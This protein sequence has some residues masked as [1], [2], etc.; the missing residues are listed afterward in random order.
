VKFVSAR[1]LQTNPVAVWKR[2]RKQK[3][4]VITSN[5]KPVGVLTYADED[6]LKDVLT[7]LRQGRALSAAAR[8]RERATEKHLDQVSDHDTET[9]IQRTRARRSKAML[10]RNR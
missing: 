6:S 5:E 3:D 1:D 7:I 2:L 9:I 4:L 10:K 8:I